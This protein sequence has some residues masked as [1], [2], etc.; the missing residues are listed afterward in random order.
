MFDKCSEDYFTLGL[1][2]YADRIFEEYVIPTMAD[3]FRI[4]D[5]YYLPALSEF[6]GMKQDGSFVPYV[7]KSLIH[8]LMNVFC[9][10]TVWKR[11]TIV[12]NLPN[13]LNK[14]IYYR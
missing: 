14:L 2:N 8:L 13:W 5:K 6:Y 7:E 9:K 3:Y 11:G 10:S 12:Y 1:Y 4:P